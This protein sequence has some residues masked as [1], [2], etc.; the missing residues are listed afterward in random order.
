M[1]EYIKQWFKKL[2]CCHEWVEIER[3][4][5][6]RIA[7]FRVTNADPH[8]ATALSLGKTTFIHVCEHCGR[9]N[10]IETWGTSSS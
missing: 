7:E 4:K 2:T 9:I 5:V 6:D 8:V 3:I 10:K 1:I